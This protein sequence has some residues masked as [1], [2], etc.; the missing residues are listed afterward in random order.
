V[1]TLLG[2]S[3][4]VAVEPV[5]EI[6]AEASGKYRYVVSRIA[7]RYVGDLLGSRVNGS[8]RR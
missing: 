3:V 1:Q 2:A 4:R 5:G 6:P 7:D 8:A